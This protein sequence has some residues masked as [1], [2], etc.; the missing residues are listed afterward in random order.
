MNESEKIQQELKEIRKTVK[1]IN[2]KLSMETFLPIVS[3]V[4]VIVAIV[5]CCW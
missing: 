2:D 4:A 1:E 5:V 3:V